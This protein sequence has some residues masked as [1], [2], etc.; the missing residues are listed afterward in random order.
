MRLEYKI[1]GTAIKTLTM[2][3]NL[4]GKDDADDLLAQVQDQIDRKCA[5]FL[6]DLKELDYINSVGLNLLINILTKARKQGGEVAIINI[7]GK[8]ENLLLITK[9]NTVFNV[10][11]TEEQAM[12]FLNNE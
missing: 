10:F 12:E 11:E 3:G 9:L 8:I 5:K 4:I 6:I 7:N 2:Q 1:S